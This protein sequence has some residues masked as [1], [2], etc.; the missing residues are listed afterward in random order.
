MKHR[1]TNLMNETF[2]WLGFVEKRF[3]GW[4]LWAWSVTQ[5]SGFRSIARRACGKSMYEVMLDGGTRHVRVLDF[6]DVTHSLKNK[7]IVWLR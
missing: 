6:V 4:A 5:I 7:I 3:S 2:L 1:I